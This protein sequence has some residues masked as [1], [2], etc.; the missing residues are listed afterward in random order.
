MTRAKLHARIMVGEEIT[1]RFTDCDQLVVENWRRAIAEAWF[2]L[3][4]TSKADQ[5]YRG[6]LD[7]DP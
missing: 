3:G 6:W 5:L 1:H 7:A 2:W 4:E